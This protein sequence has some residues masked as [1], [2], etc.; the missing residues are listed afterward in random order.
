MLL[1]LQ[2]CKQEPQLQRWMAHLCS[3]PFAARVLKTT[4]SIYEASDNT[5]CVLLGKVGFYFGQLPKVTKKQQTVSVLL[6]GFTALLHFKVA[7]GKTVFMPPKGCLFYDFWDL[8]TL[9]MTLHSFGESITNLFQTLLGVF[10]CAWF[11]KK[12]SFL[13]LVLTSSYYFFFFPQFESEDQFNSSVKTL[14]SRLPKQRYLKSICDEI[15][16]FKIT[17]RCA[18]LFSMLCSPCLIFMLC[19]KRHIFLSFWT[20]SRCHKRYILQ[21]TTSIFASYYKCALSK[22]TMKN[23]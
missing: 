6:C 4:P 19:N 5:L 8:L 20:V 16:H 3:Q 22:C 1:T 14:L 18:G 23:K 9:C 10:S 15:H 2:L 7:E 12:K 17:K 13:I 21:L 11:K